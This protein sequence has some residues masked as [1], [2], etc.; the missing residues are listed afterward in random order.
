MGAVGFENTAHFKSAEKN[1]SGYTYAV[2]PVRVVQLFP[3]QIHES[4]V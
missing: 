1:F 4:A 3:E 2:N